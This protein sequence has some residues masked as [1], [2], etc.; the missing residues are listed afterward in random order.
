[1][2]KDSEKKPTDQNIPDMVNLENLKK[3]NP[4]HTS[5]KNVLQ[6]YIM[7]LER[8]IDPIKE[9]MQNSLRSRERMKKELADEYYGEFYSNIPLIRDIIPAFRD[10]Q[11]DFNTK[12]ERQKKDLV[13]FIM[14]LVDTT[15]E[16]KEKIIEVPVKQDESQKSEAGK[17]AFENKQRENM[18]LMQETSNKAHHNSMRNTVIKMAK[19]EEEKI[20]TNNLSRDIFG[21]DITEVE[22]KIGG[23]KK[24]TN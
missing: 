3:L 15:N 9:S 19:T 12:V 24:K 21:K 1:M 18:M 14:E 22:W 2:E 17:K 8:H 10:A 13:L 4:V 23:R 16:I 5:I 7:V 6:K 20:L 11:L